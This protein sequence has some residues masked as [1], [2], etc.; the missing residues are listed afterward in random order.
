[1]RPVGVVTT[2]VDRARLEE[3]WIRE[4]IS[5]EICLDKEEDQKEIIMDQDVDLA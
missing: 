4:T 3:F 1:M 2:N 5:G